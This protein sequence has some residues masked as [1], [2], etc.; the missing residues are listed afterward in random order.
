M[1]NFGVSLRTSSIFKVHAIII[2]DVSPACLCY[3]VTHQLP[4]RHP[5]LAQEMKPCAHVVSFWVTIDQSPM[6]QDG[7]GNSVEASV[8]NSQWDVNYGVMA[9]LSG[10]VTTLGVF[11]RLHIIHDASQ[12]NLCHVYVLELCLIG[13][14]DRILLLS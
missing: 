7:T 10:M 11:L 9:F 2:T 13:S 5:K 14:I 12:N 8:V 3:T 4:L 6:I 1:S